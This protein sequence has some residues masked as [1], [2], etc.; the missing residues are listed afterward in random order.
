MPPDAQ[1]SSCFFASSMNSGSVL[2]GRSL[3]TATMKGMRTSRVICVS[4]VG[5]YGILAR[6]WGPAVSV[7]APVSDSV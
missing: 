4:A 3:R 5:S 6:R 2:A 1:R 7:P